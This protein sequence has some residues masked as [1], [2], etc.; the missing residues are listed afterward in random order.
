MSGRDVTVLEKDREGPPESSEEAWQVWQRAGV[1]QFRQLHY[2]QPRVRHLL[3]EELPAVRDRVEALGGCRFNPLSGFLGATGD[4]SA[5]EGDERF[6]TITGRRSMLE[7]A[8]AQVAREAPRV[9]IVRGVTASELL[10]GAAARPGVPHVRGVRTAAG[11]EI[12]ADLVVDAMGRR[13]R[14][15]QWVVGAGGRPPYEEA[16]DAAPQR[17]CAGNDPACGRCAQG[18]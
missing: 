4:R 16:S 7:A 2:M 10:L 13:S 12:E 15:T 1:S 9:T 11:T 6:E 17:V 3:D 5:R 14:L 18:T 8:F